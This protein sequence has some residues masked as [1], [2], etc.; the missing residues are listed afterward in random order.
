MGSRKRKD[1]SRREF[2]GAATATTLAVTLG[3]CGGGGSDPVGITPL[4]DGVVSGVVNEV[5][6]LLNNP[7]TTPATRRDKVLA[8]L[9]SKAAVQ[10]AGLSEVGVWAVFQDATPYVLIDNRI[11]EAVPPVDFHLPKAPTDLPSDKRARLMRSFGPAFADERTLNGQLLTQG[12]YQVV[13]QTAT[14]AQLKTVS[15]DGVFMF[16]GHGGTAPLPVIG[17]NGRP[18]EDANHQ[19]TLRDG[20]AYATD[21]PVPANW[22]IS[23]NTPEMAEVRL[24]RAAICNHLYSQVGSQQIFRTTFGITAAFVR[25]YM[26]FGKDSLVWFNSCLS[27]NAKAQDFVSACISKGAGLFV[28]WTN[29][30]LDGGVQSASPFILDRLMGLNLIQ[31]PATPQRPFE[32]PQVW[33]ELKS[34][35]IHIHPSG[36]PGGTTEIVYR[37]G[38]GAYGLLNPTIKLIN[39]RE[40]ARPMADLIGIFGTP[41][42]E[43]Q[44]LINDAP[45]NIVSWTDDKIQI[46]LPETGPLSCGNVQVVVRGHKSNIRQIT[47][48]TINAHYKMTGEE[49]LKAEGDLRIMMRADVCQY[50]KDPGIVFIQ[51]TVGAFSTTQSGGVLTGSGA[52]KTNCGQNTIDEQVWRGSGTWKSIYASSQPYG[53]VCALRIDT[54]LKQGGIAFFFGSDGVSD[55]IKVTVKDCGGGSQTQ[56]LPMEPP[57]DGNTILD[58][59]VPGSETSLPILGKNIT[60]NNDFSFAAGSMKSPAGTPSSEL[61]WE[62]PM[63]EYPPDAKNAV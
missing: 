21:D 2:L 18:I 12:G 36:D 60:F 27:Q 10:Q 4:P 62:A 7:A 26:S 49:T 58:I 20:I 15:G 29:S 17:S 13:K 6:A 22:N 43:F 59:P 56:L 50:R 37:A 42:S 44:V 38:A 35:G 9:K 40:G 1:L 24:G 23:D 32:Y 3:G 5:L 16:A 55:P 45:A 25:A 61:T 52:K 14:M 54:L 48:W 8:L 11:P 30:V 53:F 19:W 28:G 39:V 33:K 51:P 41:A 57:V 31:K 34:K 47:K 63:V 46:E